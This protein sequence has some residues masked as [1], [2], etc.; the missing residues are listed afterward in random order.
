MNRLSS[1]K[2]RIP[3]SDAA[4]GQVTSTDIRKN[5]KMP[6]K[7]VNVKLSE[8]PHRITLSGTE[9]NF[10]PLFTWLSDRV[11]P[12]A[13]VQHNRAIF[14][15]A[16][17]PTISDTNTGWHVKAKPSRRFGPPSV[18]LYFRRKNDLALFLLSTNA[19]VK[20]HVL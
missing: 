6:K 1:V 5:I 18:R 13:C 10:T 2:K 3:R 20:K 17:V 16:D 19:R 4:W 9:N 11:G 14:R 12:H 15:G 8:Y 7:R